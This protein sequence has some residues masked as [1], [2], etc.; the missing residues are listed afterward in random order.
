MRLTVS[1]IA[2][3][4]G[5][6]S[7]TGSS[8]VAT[9]GS[10][11]TKAERK[12][13]ACAD[14][15]LE[16]SSTHLDW[17]AENSSI[18]SKSDQVLVLPKA[19]KV[20]SIDSMQLSTFF[21]AIQKGETVNTVI[22]LPAPADC[23]LFTINNNLKKDAAIPRGMIS[24]TGEAQGQKIALSYQNGYLTGYVNWFDIAYEI[25][26]TT[27]NRQPYFIVYAKQPAT[28]NNNKNINPSDTRP[29]IIELKYDK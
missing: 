16:M 21:N 4:I 14:V 26:T 7:C 1:I 9:T 13:M 22:P 3:T 5:L 10:N 23:Q 17:F 6:V 18:L 29:E 20:Y 11:T 27:V 28:E 25:Q 8:K 19:Y 15:H 24:A 2:L 12:K